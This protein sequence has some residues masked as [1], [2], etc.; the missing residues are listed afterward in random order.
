[1]ANYFSRNYYGT[2]EAPSIANN[3]ILV[4]LGEGVPNVYESEFGYSVRLSM[5]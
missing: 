5:E 1:M 4:P 2:R 3:E